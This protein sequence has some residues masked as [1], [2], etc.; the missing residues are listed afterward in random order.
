MTATS[1]AEVATIVRRA[2]AR[3]ASTDVRPEL[4][5]DGERIASDTLGLTSMAYV[6]AVIAVEDEIGAAFADLLF[7]EVE[8]PTVGDVVAYAVAAGPAGVAPAD[9]PRGGRS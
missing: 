9:A 5:R 8:D 3:E 6:R 7:L 2:L 1:P 4:L